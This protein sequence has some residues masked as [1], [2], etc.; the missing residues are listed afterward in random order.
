MF[1][2]R[3]ESIPRQWSQNIESKSCRTDSLFICEAFRTV[4]LSEISTGQSW[5][6]ISRGWVDFKNKSPKNHLGPPR[7]FL[8]NILDR[9]KNFFDYLGPPRWFSKNYFRFTDLLIFSLGFQI[10]LIPNITFKTGNCQNLKIDLLATLRVK[11]RRKNFVVQFWNV[12]MQSI[13]QLKMSHVSKLFMTVSSWLFLQQKE[14]RKYLSQRKNEIWLIFI[15][16]IPAALCP[17]INLSYY[18][19]THKVLLQRII[20]AMLSEHGSYHMQ[21]YN[22]CNYIVSPET[23]KNI[24]INVL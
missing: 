3:S 1:Q 8:A 18:D 23:F 9:A 22:K 6:K 20:C 14:D 21:L 17:V 10:A 2:F 11:I 7:W 16:L 12:Q 4:I 19:S 5:S 24:E 13:K 15:V